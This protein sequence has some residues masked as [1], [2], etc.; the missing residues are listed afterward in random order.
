MFDIYEIV[1]FQIA[2]C[3]QNISNSK[4]SFRLRTD[5]FSGKMVAHCHVGAH[6][7][8]GGIMYWTIQGG[9]GADYLVP[10]KDFYRKNFHSNNN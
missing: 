4:S 7:D 10:D 5:S 3:P 1:I 6:S 9:F 2:V 8:N